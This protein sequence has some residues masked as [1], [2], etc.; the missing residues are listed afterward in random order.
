[1]LCPG[2][3]VSLC[4]KHTGASHL[5]P[6]SPIQH[7]ATGDHPIPSIGLE[8]TP[9]CF[10]WQVFSAEL[11]Q[12]SSISYTWVID[13]MSMFAYN[14]QTYSVRFKKPATYR[15]K[16]RQCYKPPQSAL[17]EANK[18]RKGHRVIRARGWVTGA[19]GAFLKQVT[20]HFALQF[21][22]L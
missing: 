7:V 9:D 6:I 16:V 1:M 14:G 2:A 11:S 12:G 13:N 18:A 3:H 21:L 20:Y 10:A 17:S 19:P 5:L 4:F 15:L 8:S 22:H